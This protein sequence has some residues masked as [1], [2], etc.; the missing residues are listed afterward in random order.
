MVKLQKVAKCGDG[1][2]EEATPEAKPGL[3]PTDRPLELGFM[4]IDVVD[5][6]RIDSSLRSLTHIRL[7]KGNRETLRVVQCFSAG[8]GDPACPIILIGLQLGTGR[9]VRPPRETL[10]DLQA[11]TAGETLQVPPP[12]VP[13]ECVEGASDNAASST[14]QLMSI[15]RGRLSGTGVAVDVIG[16]AD[17]V[18]T[19]LPRPACGRARNDRCAEG[20]FG[21][22]AR[23]RRRD[24]LRS[25]QDARTACAPHIRI[26]RNTE[27]R[28]EE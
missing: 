18:G 10:R 8:L 7:T 12:G 24:G 16:E 5:S 15:A 17:Q 28:T 26:V 19:G 4:P 20:R 6:H 25:Y 21:R 3:S 1:T 2:E 22:A 9:A 14:V 11:K 23:R 27:G 13:S